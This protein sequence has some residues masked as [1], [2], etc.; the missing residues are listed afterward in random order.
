M[1]AKIWLANL[2]LY[3]PALDDFA[4]S[5][6]HSLGASVADIVVFKTYMHDNDAR[7]VYNIT[8]DAAHKIEPQA[9]D[10]SDDS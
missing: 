8:G 7:Q 5:I 6:E 9:N 2:G 1:A 10:P 4:V 3:F